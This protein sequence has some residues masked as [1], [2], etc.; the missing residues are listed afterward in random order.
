[1]I[2]KGY[3]LETVEMLKCPFC[4]GVGVV[5]GVVRDGY[6]NEPEDE[7]D[8]MAYYV[9]CHACAAQGGWAK[10]TSG[11]VRLWNMRQVS[12]DRLEQCETQLAGCGVAAL[13]YFEDGVH[14]ALPGDYGW[15]A[16]YQT[17]LELRKKY[18]ALLAVCRDAYEGLTQDACYTCG[19]EPGCN[20]DCPGCEW[21][22]R[23]WNVI[24]DCVGQED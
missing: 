24:R 10:S 4:D 20:I 11:A 7:P 16:S 14:L 6:E 8:R 3:L 9:H 13:G 17:V 1:M 18:V 2:R 21:V 12:A 19:S 5:A 22:S 23:A 15:S